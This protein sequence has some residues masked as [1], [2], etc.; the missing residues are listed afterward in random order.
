M[1]TIDTRWERHD[2]GWDIY[3]PLP[4]TDE[5][6]VLWKQYVEEFEAYKAG[7]AK[8]YAAIESL[9]R[10]SSESVQREL[11]DEYYQHME[12]ALPLFNDSDATLD[13]IIQ[14]NVDVSNT[15]VKRDAS[16]ADTANTT[17]IAV[18]I[19]AL[20]ILVLLGMFITRST[21]RQLGG[22]PNY[23]SQVVSQVAA[24]DMTVAIHLVI[25]TMVT[26]AACS[27]PSW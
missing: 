14:L 26:P 5:E 8:V 10:N 1:K 11:F 20:V 7:M 27:T 12:D 4:K 23:V 18:A 22:E 24:G 21:L 16:S 17:M 3:A 6:A 13:K 2:E 9:S 15:A 25:W 19:V